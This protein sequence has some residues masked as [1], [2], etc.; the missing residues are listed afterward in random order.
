M[1]KK[2]LSERISIINGT[3]VHLDAPSTIAH[4]DHIMLAISQLESE[5]ERLQA[6]NE[7]IERHLDELCEAA[8]YY[9]RKERDGLEEE[10]N[11]LRA[12]L[13]ISDSKLF[14]AD[15]KL[16]NASTTINDLIKQRDEA[17]TELEK[18]K[19]P[20]F[21]DVLMRNQ[22]LTAELARVLK[23]DDQLL[24]RLAE[25]LEWAKWAVKP[26]SVTMNQDMHEEVAGLIKKIESNEVSAEECVQGI[27]SLL[28]ED[29]DS[30][31]WEEVYN[32]MDP[33]SKRCKPTKSSVDD[34]T[35]ETVQV[36]VTLRRYA[37]GRWQVDESDLVP[38]GDNIIAEGVATFAIPKAEH[39]TLVERLRAVGAHNVFPIPEELLNEVA[40]LENKVKQ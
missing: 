24:K 20:V 15:K 12:A 26:G 7:Y 14:E 25:V 18:Y 2:K 28:G 8:L 1:S 5:N 3:L 30:Y 6:E 4:V 36:P 9:M 34:Q 19:T 33:N 37:N 27:G 17:R 40:E 21:E 38:Q 10:R 31:T 29:K 35:Y 13:T 39:K 16:A 23:K 11:H 32:A 22:E